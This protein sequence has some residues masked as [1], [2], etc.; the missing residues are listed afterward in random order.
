V[1]RILIV[2]DEKI[3][4]FDLQIR[5]KKFGYKAPYVVSTGEEA[6]TRTR[7][8]KPDLILMDI[9]LAGDITGIEAVIQLRKEHIDVPV[10]Y[11]TAYTDKT[12]KEQAE[13]TFPQAFL[14]KP[15]MHEL[16]QDEIKKAFSK[17]G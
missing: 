12:T 8:M 2:E 3:I 5:I 4:A 9:M 14:M 1:K 13:S 15:V 17:T 10:I 6:I 7:A 16:L 11:I